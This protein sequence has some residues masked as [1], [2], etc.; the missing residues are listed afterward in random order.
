[1]APRAKGAYDKNIQICLSSAKGTLLDVYE[2]ISRG[3]GCNYRKIKE[4][5]AK[6][7]IKIPTNLSDKSFKVYIERIHATP[8][9]DY[10]IITF[11]ILTVLISK[12]APDISRGSLELPLHIET[13]MHIVVKSFSKQEKWTATTTSIIKISELCHPFT[14]K[15]R[16]VAIWHTKNNQA[17]T[18]DLKCVERQLG[19][20]KCI[21]R[22]RFRPRQTPVSLACLY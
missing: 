12:N 1:M 17:S 6:E 15:R 19:V 16:K 18:I 14:F 2:R 11:S 5:M 22:P 13:K 9:C 8:V 7:R 10:R 21:H 20:R 3:V 4:T